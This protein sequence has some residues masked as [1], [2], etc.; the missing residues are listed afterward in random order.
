MTFTAPLTVFSRI[1]SGADSPAS[2]TLLRRFP[3]TLLMTRWA[4]A[5]SSG[6]WTVTEPLVDSAVIVPEEATY[7]HRSTAPLTLLL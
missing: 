1:F 4:G 3:L 6:S 7:M 5:A 2:S